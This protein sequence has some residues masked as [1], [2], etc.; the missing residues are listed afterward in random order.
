MNILAN[1]FGLAGGQGL[2]I[3]LVVILLFGAK[4]LPELARGLGQSMR[5]FNKGKEGLDEDEEK[6]KLGASSDKA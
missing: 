3:L 1:I 6:K 4:K 2:I 5:E